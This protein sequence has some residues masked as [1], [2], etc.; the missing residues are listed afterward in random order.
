M[1]Q[2]AGDIDMTATAVVVR[3]RHGQSLFMRAGH[4]RVTPPRAAQ[5][6]REDT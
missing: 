6:E 3:T 2:A 5:P 1:V 4:H